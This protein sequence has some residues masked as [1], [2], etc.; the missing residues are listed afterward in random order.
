VDHEEGQDGYTEQHRY[1]HDQPA[2]GVLQHVSPSMAAPHWITIKVTI[3]LDY[4][5]QA[6]E[7]I[8]C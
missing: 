1:Q 2:N 4:R 7:F 8:A 5:Y 6:A 3:T